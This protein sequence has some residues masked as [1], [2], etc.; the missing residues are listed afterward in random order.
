MADITKIPERWLAGLQIP[1]LTTRTSLSPVARFDQLLPN[2]L[3]ERTTGGDFLVVGDDHRILGAIRPKCSFAEL[4]KTVGVTP[5]ECAEFMR[6]RGYARVA[7]LF[8]TPGDTGAVDY[9]KRIYTLLWVEMD[10]GDDH[11]TKLSSMPGRKKT[12]R[13]PKRC[14]GGGQ[15]A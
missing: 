2:W 8:G 15:P 11:L 12:P 4:C 14:S 3:V 7:N 9:L 13:Q 10:L 1:R 6:E 5:I